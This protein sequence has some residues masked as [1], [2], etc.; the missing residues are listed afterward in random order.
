MSVCPF[1]LPN[2][3]T[4]GQVRYGVYSIRLARGQQAASLYAATRSVTVDIACFTSSFG[5][6][7]IRR[8][9]VDSVAQSHV[10]V[11]F[12][13]VGR[14]TSLVRPRTAVIKHDTQDNRDTVKLWLLILLTFHSQSS[15]FI[16]IYAKLRTRNYL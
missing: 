16:K 3:N 11:N 5:I 6:Q 7:W 14:A 2:V 12:L 4:V 13:N 9:P 15:F 10:G 8:I 1:F